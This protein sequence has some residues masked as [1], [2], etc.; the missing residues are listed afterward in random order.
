MALLQDLLNPSAEGVGEPK[1][2]PVSYLTALNNLVG[3]TAAVDIALRFT[4]K[5]IK[6]GEEILDK[7]KFE[8]PDES[9]KKRLEQVVKLLELKSKFDHLEGR[10]YY[11]ENIALT[12]DEF[13]SVHNRLLEQGDARL[14]DWMF[15]RDVLTGATRNLLRHYGVPLTDKTKVSGHIGK[16]IHG[17]ETKVLPGMTTPQLVDFLI[18][19]EIAGERVD[20]YRI[21]AGF[22]D[23]RTAMEA[24]SKFRGD[25]EISPSLY[26]ALGL[27]SLEDVMEVDAEKVK[28]LNKLDFKGELGS[29]TWHEIHFNRFV[30]N[31]IKGNPN[32]K[33]NASQARRARLERLAAIAQYERAGDYLFAFDGSVQ[34]TEEIYKLPEGKMPSPQSIK[35]ARAVLKVKNVITTAREID[36]PALGLL[37]KYSW[38][39]LGMDFKEDAPN[40]K[41]GV[42]NVIAEYNKVNDAYKKA[43]G[44]DK[45]LG[46]EEYERLNT[47]NGDI[48]FLRDF[49]VRDIYHLDR[50][51][52]ISGAMR[53]EDYE[54]LKINPSSKP[55]L[56]DSLLEK[57]YSGEDIQEAFKGSS[58]K[59]LDIDGMLKA[60]DGTRISLVDLVNIAKI[61]VPVD[62]AVGIVKA[63][64]FASKGIPYGVLHGLQAHQITPEQLTAFDDAVGLREYQAGGKFNTQKF[65][66]DL[67][68]FYN[69]TPKKLSV[70]QA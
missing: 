55:W 42:L 13:V 9:P 23:V 50:A 70:V 43:T 60:L 22:N 16:E 39:R 64:S 56:I 5:D 38:H 27:T 37:A 52:K 20:E 65:F 17:E 54:A 35:Y 26:V 10:D 36:S 51:K 30:A 46:Q 58:T 21:V 7:F 69:I 15:Y 2:I 29:H 6:I 63:V 24:A 62:Y 41:E 3:S 47:F 45:D 57:G 40:T 1:T 25:H 48:R 66:R 32:V 31:Y 14:K 28:Q 18:A 61:G 33:G 67:R 11:V 4:P 53:F 19:K 44:K 12:L 34:Q 68:A 8:E 59:R 49:D